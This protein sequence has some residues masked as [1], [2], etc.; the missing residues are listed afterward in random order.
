[1]ERIGTVDPNRLFFLDETGAKTNMTR[2]YGRA[3]KGIRAWDF[4]P[5]GHW[6]TTTLVAAVGLKGVIA[7]MMVEGPMDGEAFEAYVRQVLAPCLR[8]DMIVVM[9]NLGP[10]KMP[11][12]ETLLK[13]AGAEV[14]YLPPYSPDF[15]PIELMWS[16]VKNLLRSIKA[17]SKEALWDAVAA[18]LRAITS[19]DAAAWFKHCAVG[20]KC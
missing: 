1:M 18:A 9:D 4:A 5:H 6:N 13:Q 2:L 15:N 11:I 8:P 14:W 17:R 16:K 12:V 19:Q 7:P 20:S 10:H 3:R